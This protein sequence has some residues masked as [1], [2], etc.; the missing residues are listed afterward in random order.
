[1]QIDELIPF[2]SSID[3]DM[4]SL[5]FLRILISFFSFSFVKSAAIITGCALSAPKKAYLRCL[6]NSFKTNPS[7]IFSIS[8]T[9]SSLLLEFSAF[10]SFRLK[11]V[12]FNSTL[13]LRHSVSRS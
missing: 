12:Y 10:F 1:M 2:K 13:A 6:D 5:N 11:T 3:Q 4:A 8:C 9:F 7:K